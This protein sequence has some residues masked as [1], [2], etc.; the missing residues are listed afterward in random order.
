MNEYLLWKWLHILSST[1]LFGAGIG[2]ALH[3]LLSVLTRSPAVVAAAARHTVLADWLFTLPTMIFQPASGLYLAHLM[4]VPLDAPWV[5]WS[6]LLWFAALCCWVPVAV[7]QIRMRG[8][9][10]LAAG[11]GTAL[12]EMFWRCFRW[13][14]VL[15][16]PA[17]I[18]FVAIFYL[19][20]FKPV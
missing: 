8:L 7:L 1:L 17:L 9:A 6:L 13:W 5:R 18:A 19:M 16:W 2:T 10:A 3:F 15:G 4:G 14:F 11:G 20:V 12:P